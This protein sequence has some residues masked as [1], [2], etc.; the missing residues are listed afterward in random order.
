MRELNI[1][2]IKGKYPNGFSIENDLL[3]YDSTT[4]LPTLTETSKMK[5]LLLAI[6]TGGE[7]EYTV[8]TVIHKVSSND[9]LIVSEGQVIGDYK[10][11]ADAKG[12]CLLLSY[13]FFQEI[14]SNVKE[15]TTL[16]L[17][18]RHHPVFHAEDRLVSEL[19]NYIQAVKLKILDLEHEFRRELVAT[20]LKVLIYD[21]CNVIYRVQQVEKTG[22]SRGETIFSD[23]IRLVEKE[24]RSERRVSWYAEQLYISPKYLSE[25]IKHISKRTPSEW[26][27]YYVMMEIRVLLKNSKMSIKQIAEEL[28]FPN[29]SFLGKYFK[30]RYG[31]SPSQFRR[32]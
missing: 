22:K 15:L 32:S 10:M 12:V 1:D 18:A 3:L 27:D 31:K 29:Q 5:C 26:I 2:F 8:D 14:V 30:D 19:L 16:F 9:V 21:M 23:F 24:Y 11:S 6:C 4:G 28:N 25:T 13:D 17:F 7:I 20:M